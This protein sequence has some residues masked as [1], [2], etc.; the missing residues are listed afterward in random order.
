MPE[1]KAGDVV[2]IK[3]GPFASFLSVVE[4]VN[5]AEGIVTVVVE[6]FGRRTPVSLACSEVEPAPFERGPRAPLTSLN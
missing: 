6:V 3:A 1:I 5:A 4:E 2:R